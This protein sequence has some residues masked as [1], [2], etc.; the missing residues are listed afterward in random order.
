MENALLADV[1]A[2][3][4]T[5]EHEYPVSMTSPSPDNRPKRWLLREPGAGDVK[6]LFCFP[7]SGVGASMFSHWPP[8]IGEAEVC[9]VQPPGRENRFR[10]EHFGTYEAFAQELAPWLMPYLDRPYAFFGHCAAALP[11][12]ETARELER[13]GA[14]R[15]ETVFV[16]GQ[17]APIHCPHDRFLEL[18]PD[19]LRHELVLLVRRRGAEPHATLLELSLEVLARDLTANRVYRPSA[20]TRVDFPLHVLH[21]S[22]DDEVTEEELAAWHEYSA[23]VE[24]SVLDGEH[25]DFL[26]APADLTEV[27]RHVF[28]DPQVTRRA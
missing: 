5:C 11:A 17:V 10:E 3:D 8:R 26:D 4:E 25:Y 27:I 9:M 6:R 12:F 24:R 21:W 7:Y 13:M 28:A 20:V 16:S 22:R 19:E 14:R 1:R 23:H 2:N 18:T 15:P